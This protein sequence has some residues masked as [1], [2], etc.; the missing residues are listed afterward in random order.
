LKQHRMEKHSPFPDHWV[1]RRM[2][3]AW[4]QL[5]G[6]GHMRLNINPY[7]RKDDAL[8]LRSHH[9]MDEAEELNSSR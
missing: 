6:V 9:W 3:P 4:N 8:L 5:F 1:V 7:H 2:R